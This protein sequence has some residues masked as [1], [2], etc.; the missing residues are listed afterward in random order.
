M[1]LQLGVATF[2]LRGIMLQTLT[3]LH[4]RFRNAPSP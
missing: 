2:E 3:A 4:M 1:Q